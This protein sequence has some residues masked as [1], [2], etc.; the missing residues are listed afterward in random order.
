LHSTVKSQ[1][2]HENY[3]I[4]LVSNQTAS[5]MWVVGIERIEEEESGAALELQYPRGTVHVREAEDRWL[6]L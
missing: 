1:K 2:T 6:G 5:V 4:K 3:K